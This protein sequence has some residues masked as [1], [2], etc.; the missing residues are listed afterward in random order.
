[1]WQIRKPLHPRLIHI[2]PF[3]LGTGRNIGAN[4][5]SMMGTESI[6]KRRALLH[7]YILKFTKYAKKR[8]LKKPS[9]VFLVAYAFTIYNSLL[10]ELKKNIV[11]LWFQL[12]RYNQ[13]RSRGVSF[14]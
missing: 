3:A 12:F 6:A 8:I 7:Q 2:Y 9:F 5:L 10:W 11:A 14:F 4:T 13:L 1:M